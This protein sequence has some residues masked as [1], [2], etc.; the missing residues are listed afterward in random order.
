MGTA[1]ARSDASVGWKYLVYRRSRRQCGGESKYSLLSF[2]KLNWNLVGSQHHLEGV[3][4]NTATFMHGRYLLTYGI[5]TTS[6]Y[7]EECYFDMLN[8]SYKACNAIT[9]NGIPYRVEPNSNYIGAAVSPQGYKIVWWTSVGT[10]GGPGTFSY[11]AN[12]GSGWNGPHTNT[13]GGYNNFSYVY[14][15]FASD[16]SLWVAGQLYMGAYPNGKYQAAIARIQL[17]QPIGQL[18]TLRSR[19]TGETVK[20][21]ADIWVHPGTDDLHI[22]AETDQ[23]RLVYFHEKAASLLAGGR[24]DYPDAVFDQTY[25]GR[26][27]TLPGGQGLALISGSSAGGG[28]LVRKQSMPQVGFPFDWNS[29]FMLPIKNLPSG[30]S[31]PSGLY[32]ERSTYQYGSP[33][34]TDLQFGVCDQWPDRD[35]EIQHVIV[36]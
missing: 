6:R 28:V 20:S 33:V 1:F 2:S 19:Q 5:S 18:W 27:A 16:G 23:G 26:L 11:I 29:A 30:Y 7:I 15:D 32:V 12:Y 13:I 25:R 8:Y 9:T 22:L 17:G 24:P 21:A 10:N 14:A 31:T 4:Q 3:Q 35:Y 34:P 36:K